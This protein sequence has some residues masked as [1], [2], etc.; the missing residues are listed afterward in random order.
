MKDSAKRL[1][2]DLT[3]WNYF[4]ACGVPISGIQRVTLNLLRS[5]RQL[6]LNF[7]MIRYDVYARTHRVVSPS[8]LNYDFS[9]PRAPSPRLRDIARSSYGHSRL[10]G[11]YKMMRFMAWKVSSSNRQDN[12]ECFEAN[13]IPQDN[14][15]L[16][17]AGA[18]WDCA[19]T[20]NAI[21]KF[22]KAAKVHVAVE[23]FDMLQ[24]KKSVFKNQRM[25]R[26]FENWLGATADVADLYICLSKYT[27]LDFKELGPKFGIRNDA[28]S[29]VITPPHEFKH[30]SRL[31]LPSDS[32]QKF[33]LCVSRVFGHKNARRAIEAWIM[34]E[35]THLL[36][37]RL[38][39]A[40]ATKAEE[41]RKIYGD[42]PGL[43]I[44]ERPSDNLLAYLYANAEFTLFP[45]LYEGW[46]MPVGESLWCGTPCIASNRTAIPEV[47]G[48]LCDYFD[49]DSPGELETL[50]M[51]AMFEP[52]F[53]Q[54]R[55]AR[56]E[57]S[58]LKSNDE[59]AQ[60]VFHT[61]T[62]YW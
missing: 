1:I 51:R 37:Y 9:Q 53:L 7:V 59:Y 45:S 15:I 19:P 50:M 52:D 29:I 40:G 44:I 49:P 14:D 21:S 34:L 56:I 11:I 4:L 8:F 23:I 62:N 61:L 25:A 24:L 54:T 5:L 47:G 13:Y 33:A 27:E 2:I 6:H 28:P 35:S 17:L 38:V 39:I 41:I 30:T 36:P 18:G 57:R 26:Q 48:E 55:A 16:Y 10:T 22:K 60:E 20:I 46:G 58:K 12:T 31:Q 43:R 3:D 42:V 32:K